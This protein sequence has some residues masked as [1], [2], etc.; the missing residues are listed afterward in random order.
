MTKMKVR[1]L[2][3]LLCL[4]MVLTLIPAQAATASL[5]LVSREQAV[6]ELLNTVG[7]GALNEAQAD[8]S[9]FSDASSVTAEYVD[10]LGVAVS[11]GII[12]GNPTK[13]L[14]PKS[15]ITRLEFALIISRSSRE[16]PAYI[17]LQSFTDVPAYAVGDVNRLVK[18]GIMS[19][20]GNGQFGSGDYLTQGQLEAILGRVKN[21]ALVRPQDDFYYAMNYEWLTGT[22]LPAGYP[23]LMSFDEVGI[24]N[25]EKLKVMVKDLIKNTDTYQEGTKEQKM[26]DFYSTIVDSENRNKQGLTPIKAYLDRVDQAKTAQ[27][28]LDTMVQFENEVGL[29]LLFSFSPNTDMKDSNRYVLYGSPLSST[30]P[31]VYMVS[32]NPQIKALY[33]GFIAQ[34]FMLAGSTQEEAASIA[35]NL[36]TFEQILAQNTMSN[37]MASKIE[38]VYNVLPIDDVAKMFPK[39]DVKAYIKNLGYNSVE[40]VVITDI[41]LMKKTGELMTDENLDI[42]KD[43]AKYRLLINSA[44]CLSDDFVKTLEA[45]NNTFSGVTTSASAEDK[46]FNMFSSVMSGYLGRMYAEKY[47]SEEAKKD[48][49]SI[50]AEIIATYQ[51]RIEK[52]SW[53]SSSTKEA[54]ITKLKSIKVKV[55]YPDTWN[56]PLEGITI[57]TYA[58]GGSLL[59]NLFTISAASAKYSKTLLD[60]PVDKSGWGMSP[61]TV[62]AMYSPTSNEIIFPAGILQAPFYDLTASREKNLGGIGMVIAHEITHAFDNNG[63]QFDKD[64]NLNNWWTQEDFTVFQQ[65][66]QSVIDLYNGIEIAPNA[67]SNGNLTVSENVSD[68]GAM[69][70]IL[71]IM[72]GMPNANYKELFENNA[73][74]WHM[75]ASTQMYQMLSLQDVHAP[76]KLRVNQVLRNYQEFYDTYDIKPGDPMYLAP[77][78]RVTVW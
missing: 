7:L 39:T 34:I 8:L 9:N 21:L 42:L 2:T 77:E 19:G 41:G 54:A 46:A 29:N 52:L 60:K 74:I 45:F 49:Q 16:L 78:D 73:T 57:K 32:E 17:A 15:N 71:D 68:I 3:M 18:S 55:G 72:K 36:Y 27:E 26:A 44:S 67:I 38:N 30:L 31:S 43:F 47:F 28:L 20:Y 35:Q 66:C 63:S 4:S 24:S 33:Q 53:M 69:A 25:N 59:G 37:E 51:K 10:E 64:G 14:N 65:K 56:D 6:A 12:V 1:I 58:E 62:N 22:K 50:V 70:C 48:V 23:G 61:Q 5:D 13:A 11:N 75:T 40:Q 76:N